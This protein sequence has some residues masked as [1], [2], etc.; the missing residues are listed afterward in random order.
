MAEASPSANAFLVL[1]RFR[2]EGEDDGYNGP[3]H[4]SL[5]RQLQLC[6]RRRQSGAEPA[7]R[8]F[9]PS[10][11]EGARLFASGA[12]AGISTHRRPCRSEEHTSE[13]QSLMRISYAVF[14]LNKKT[15][16]TDHK[17]APAPTYTE[18]HEHD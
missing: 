6:T 17:K 16:E 9:T 7:R 11:R 4:R 10:R 15:Q 3:S 5:Q 18:Y 14:C 12:Q 2:F 8:L 1:Q 13:L